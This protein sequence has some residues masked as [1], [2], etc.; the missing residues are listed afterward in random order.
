MKI[1]EITVTL[2]TSCFTSKCS[3]ASEAFDVVRDAYVGVH[4]VTMEPHEADEWM[5]TLVHMYRGVTISREQRA[6]RARVVE[7][8]E[9]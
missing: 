4:G 6:L 1:I 8:K 2:G 9:E 3:S 7:V 5:S